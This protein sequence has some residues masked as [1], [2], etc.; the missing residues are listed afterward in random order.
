[1]KHATRAI[2][3]IVLLVTSIGRAETPGNI[4]S[5]QAVADVVAGKVTTANAAWWGFDPDDSTT[6][7]QSAIDSGAKRVVVPDMGRD[8]IVRPIRLAGNQE[9]VL[10]RGVTVTAKR[11][12]YKGGGDSVFTASDVANLVIKGDGAT[13]RMQKEDYIVGKVLEDL[14][15]KRWFGPYKKAEWR[16]ALSLRGCTHVKVQGL[17]LRDSG[18]DGIYVAGGKQGPSKGIELR[19]VVCDN[20]YRQG[21]SVID[22][23]GLV[24]E[25]S[26]FRNTWGTPPSSGVDFEP[27][28]PNER[29]QNVHFRH[30]RFE[31]NYGDGIQVH[32][33]HTVQD[34]SILFEDCYVTSRRGAGIRVSKSKDGGPKGLIEFRNCHVEN[35]VAYGIKV[36]DKVPTAVKVRFASCTLRDVAR[37]RHYAGAWAPIWLQAKTP[38]TLGGIEFSNC[39]VED[40]RDRPAI[41]VDSPSE[42][43]DI[44]GTLTIRN[45]RAPKSDL[46]PGL[47]IVVE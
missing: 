28:G 39:L 19:N 3:T 5:P 26:V 34:V 29:I 31:D 8:W 46:G 2:L 16:M 9:L 20:N 15:W 6:A 38:F 13:V 11:G 32:L 10:E 44:T 37:D 23:D 36:Q 1:M 25:H 42:L 24:V 45:P 47:E 18:G 4:A 41:V 33:P 22:V 27:D 35:T 12:E 7:L 40:D 21:I 17:T 30:C 14:G 43:T